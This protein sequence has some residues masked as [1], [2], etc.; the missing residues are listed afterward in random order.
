MGAQ[1]MASRRHSPYIWQQD[2]ANMWGVNHAKNAYNVE[3]I[4]GAIDVQ[5]DYR[6][7]CLTSGST[8]PCLVTCMDH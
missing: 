5:L 8:K 2:G 1:Y 4:V 7:F 3:E 6:F